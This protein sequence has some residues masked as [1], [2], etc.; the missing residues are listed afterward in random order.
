MPRAAEFVSC[1]SS[2]WCEHDDTQ[3]GVI[4][5]AGGLIL[6]MKRG[7]GDIEGKKSLNL[8]AGEERRH[9]WRQGSASKGGEVVYLRYLGKGME[10]KTAINLNRCVLPEDVLPRVSDARR[11]W[12]AEEF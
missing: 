5:N 3:N 2:R 4:V 10:M 9:D 1:L 7:A 6:G 11:E 12:Q 8:H